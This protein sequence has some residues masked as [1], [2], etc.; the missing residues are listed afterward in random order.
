MCSQTSCSLTLV[1]DSAAPYRLGLK[2][3]KMLGKVTNC[4]QVP[5]ILIS[6]FSAP[7]GYWINIQLYPIIDVLVSNNK[8]EPSSYFHFFS[9]SFFLVWYWIDFS[10]PVSNNKLGPTLILDTDARDGYWILPDAP[11][12]ITSIGSFWLKTYQASNAERHSPVEI[13]II[14][15]NQS[16]EFNSRLWLWILYSVRKKKCIKDRW[17]HQQLW[18]STCILWIYQGPN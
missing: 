15:R 1:F 6:D 5:Y 8:L 10:N 11:S 13:S 9:F 2:I 12:L 14:R 18:V 4:R 17:K 3:S 16:S 7:V